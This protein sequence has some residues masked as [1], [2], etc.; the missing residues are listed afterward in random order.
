MRD[1]KYVPETNPYLPRKKRMTLVWRNAF[2]NKELPKTLQ[3][4]DQDKIQ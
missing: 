2:P 4:R 1:R 3:N